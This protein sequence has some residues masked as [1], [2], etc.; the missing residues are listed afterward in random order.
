MRG[1]VSSPPVRAELTDQGGRRPCSLARALLVAVVPAGAGALAW[2]LVAPDVRDLASHAYRAGLF[3]R[4]GFA[5]WDGGWYAGHHLPGYSVLFPPLA[6]ALG[7]RLVG[8]LAAVAAAAAFAAL[9]ARG[10]APRPAL[11]ASAWFGV[12]VTT[13]LFSGRLAFAAGLAAGLGALLAGRRTAALLAVLTALLS[14]VAALFLALAAAARRTPLLV[15]AA[16]LPVALL[17]LLFPEG[18]T[19]PFVLSAFWPCVAVAV[20][21]LALGPRERRALRAGAALYGVLCVVL[22]LVPNPV[23][24]NAA[25]LGALVAGPLAAGAL[26]AARPRALAVVALPLAA[27]PWLAAVRDVAD[28]SGDPSTDRAYVAPLLARIEAAP[29]PPGRL[30]IPLTRNH[31]EARLAAPRVP[32]A[33]GWERQ[34]DRKLNALFYAGRLT[35]GRYRRWLTRT[36]VEWVALPDVPLDASA[37]AEARLLRAGVVPGLEPRPRAGRW[38]LW[39]AAPPDALVPGPARLLAHGTDT[40]L[41]D[42]PPGALDVLVRVRWTPYWRTRGGCVARAPGG[43]TRVRARGPGHVR[44]VTSFSPG[45]VGAR[46]PRCG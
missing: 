43:W 33:R 26:L 5:L 8:A 44:L 36:G 20:G 17:A 9:A 15:A 31:Q 40:L 7:V 32:L 2:L 30:E 11:A 14:P 37:R 39:R 22:F 6:W 41:L 18:G 29:G 12:A 23:G 42:V 35:P 27:W 4:E 34:L 28:A 24:G 25:R 1:G 3:G 10:L 21:A 16:L 13:L 38:R 45:R 46:S 19:E